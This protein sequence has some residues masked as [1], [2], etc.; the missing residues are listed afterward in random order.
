MEVYLSKYAYFCKYT[1]TVLKLSNSL[2]IL[3]EGVLYFPT[4]QKVRL[5][6]D[7]KNQY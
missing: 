5:F 4:E 6:F 7:T 2:S 3:E 1:K